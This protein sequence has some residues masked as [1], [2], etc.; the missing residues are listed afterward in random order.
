MEEEVDDDSI[1]KSP[2]GSSFRTFDGTDYSQIGELLTFTTCI[3]VITLCVNIYCSLWTSMILKQWNS[4]IEAFTSD[5]QQSSDDNVSDNTII[6]I[7]GTGSS[8]YH[9][10]M[11]F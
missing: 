10:Q 3:L 11:I 6:L 2:F 7:Y 4:N 8:Q 9:E 5:S 1:M